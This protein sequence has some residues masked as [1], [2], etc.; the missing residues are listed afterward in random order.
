MLADIALTSTVAES[1]IALGGVVCMFEKVI[2]RPLPLPP[3]WHPVG[4]RK[5][6]GNE[7]GSFKG[8]DLVVPTKR[9][10][11]GVAPEAQS[12]EIPR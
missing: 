9:V 6:I 11:V 5:A 12:P 2:V 3:R 10:A 1:T 8:L 7:S 4:S